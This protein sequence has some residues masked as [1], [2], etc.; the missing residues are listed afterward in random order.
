MSHY[1]PEVDIAWLVLQGFDGQRA[2]GEQHPWGLIERDRET[3]QIVAVEFWGASEQLPKE[4]LAALPAPRS[5]G[6]VIEASEL[7]KHHTG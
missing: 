4:L 3:D 7:A 1:D 2:Y 6:A 5:T